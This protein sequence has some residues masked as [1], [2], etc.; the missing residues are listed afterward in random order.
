MFRLKIYE[1]TLTIVDEKNPAPFWM[2]KTLWKT[3]RL[4]SINW[5]TISQPSTVVSDKL[6]HFIPAQTSDAISH[7]TLSDLRRS[8]YPQLRMHALH[9]PGSFWQNLDGTKGDEWIW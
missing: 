7:V 8:E 3:G 2:V 9:D 4:L 5:C 6:T 1:T